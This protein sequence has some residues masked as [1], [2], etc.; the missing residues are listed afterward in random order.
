MVPSA[1]GSTAAAAQRRN[2]NRP[3]PLDHQLGPLQE[4]HD[5]VRDRALADRDDL[6]DEALEQ[7]PGELARPLH[8][9]PVGEGGGV[10]HLGSHSDHLDPVEAALDRRRHPGGEAASPERD[11][12]PGEIGSLLDQLQAQGPLAR[13][14]RR[15]VVGVDEGEALGLGASERPLDAICDRIALEDDL[16]AR[17]LGRGD[18]AER[19]PLGHEDGGRD[20]VRSGGVGER[21]AVVAGAGGDHPGGGRASARR[22]CSAHRGA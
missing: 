9:D 1:A 20:P 3:R 14:H 16:G 18:L 15:V 10:P 6:V 5:R 19:G 2:A 22:S 7:R 8:R 13:D 12:H 21:L 4:H 11:D 17:L